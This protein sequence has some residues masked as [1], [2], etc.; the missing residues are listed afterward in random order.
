MEITWSVHEGNEASNHE[1]RSNIDLETL[2]SSCQTEHQVQVAVEHSIQEDFE[3][4]VSFCY[5]ECDYL[6][7]VE[8]W[9]QAKQP[10]HNQTEEER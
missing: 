7:I 1:Q 8:A 6:D 2:V 5:A 9:K 4:R 10:N 3:Q